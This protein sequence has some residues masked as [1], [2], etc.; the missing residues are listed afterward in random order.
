LLIIVSATLTTAMLLTQPF[1]LKHTGALE[2]FSLE[3]WIAEVI[4]VLAMAIQVKFVLP[5]MISYVFH[6]DAE[7]GG[8]VG[9]FV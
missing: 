2:R 9:L 3:W 7:E 6:I 1:D 8:N 4:A 5:R